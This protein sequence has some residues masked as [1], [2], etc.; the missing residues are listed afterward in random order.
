MEDLLG[1]QNNRKY[2]WWKVQY[3]LKMK[4]DFQIFL[5]MIYSKVRKTDSRKKSILKHQWYKWTN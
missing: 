4:C 1:K 3:K 5:K 2:Y